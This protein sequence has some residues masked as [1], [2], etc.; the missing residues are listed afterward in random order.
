MVHR[1]A[2]LQLPE[3][4]SHPT[5]R[6]S[7]KAPRHQHSGGGLPGR[8]AVEE[9]GVFLQRG[10]RKDRGF[11]PE[12]R[13][14]L[15][16]PSLHQ[17]DLSLVHSHDQDPPLPGLLHAGGVAGLDPLRDCGELALVQPGGGGDE[18][19]GIL[20]DLGGEEPVV[21]E[22]ILRGTGPLNGDPAEPN[23]VLPEQREDPQ[24]AGGADHLAD[25][26]PQGLHRGIV[27][28]VNRDAGLQLLQEGIAAGRVIG[29][30]H[31]GD[32]HHLGAHLLLL[33]RL[34]RLNRPG[35][36]GPAGHQDDA[37][38]IRCGGIAAD[39][40]AAPRVN[41]G[42]PALQRR[43]GRSAQAQVNRLAGLDRGL[44]RL[45]RGEGIGRLKHGQPIPAAHHRVN[46]SRRLDGILAGAVRPGLRAAVGGMDH[47]PQF[48]LGG[49]IDA[50]QHE[51]DE[52][53]E[54]ADHRQ[55]SQPGCGDPLGDLDA[56]ILHDPHLHET[57]PRARGGESAVDLSELDE[58]LRV[59]KI[60][61]ADENDPAGVL[62]ADGPV[63]GSEV[64][65]HRSGRFPRRHRL[66]SR[67]IG[68][69]RL[70]IRRQSPRLRLLDRR[71]DLAVDPGDLLGGELSGAELANEICPS[72][73]QG[74]LELCQGRV[75][76]CREETLGDLPHTCLVL[77]RCRGLAVKGE[78]PFAEGLLHK[79]DPHPLDRSDEDHRWLAILLRLGADERLLELVDGAELLARVHIFAVNRHHVPVVQPPPLGELAVIERGV[80]GPR[81]VLLVL[82][83][84]HDRGQVVQP[85]RRGG[86]RHFIDR[87]LLHLPVADHGKGVVVAAVHPGGDR[88][89]GGCRRPVTQRPGGEINPRGGA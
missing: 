31:G 70:G 32:L 45:H 61:G 12:V 49:V 24:G 16:H 71:G 26:R 8:E 60:G 79:G 22:E 28:D 27:D 65:P 55:V 25:G 66:A 11:D 57:A 62:R 7:V 76:T 67:R 1:R 13:T 73:I 46:L 6:G 18:R 85:Q 34:A 50:G 43:P 40:D 64:C 68:R 38:S 59:L 51:L 69:G 33:Q 48:V 84:V 2:R 87:P 21:R 4:L 20:G 86:L 15:A 63:E 37:S 3:K 41:L 81:L 30:G 53:I 75:C 47:H 58:A 44:H 36:C 5:G 83:V 23:P 89:A 42:A 29:P 9:I 52:P 77:L 17:V 39:D 56:G 14:H 80:V 10:C 54:G 74:R 88:H 35:H 72:L 82:V 19:L 78:V